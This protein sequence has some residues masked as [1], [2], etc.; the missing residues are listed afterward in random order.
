MLRRA[1]SWGDWQEVRVEGE[2]DG[3]GLKVE[4]EVVVAPMV[5]VIAAEKGV[6]NVCGRVKLGCKILYMREGAHSAGAFIREIL[7]ASCIHRSYSHPGRL[8][9][10][11][12]RMIIPFMCWLGWTCLGSG[13]ISQQ[14]ILHSV[15]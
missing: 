9:S 13:K 10:E 3:F 6:G 14:Y 11:M 15:I 1:E 7:W 8:W 4:M 12:A 5:N 2:E